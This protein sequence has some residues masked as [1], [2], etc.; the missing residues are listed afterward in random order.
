MFPIINLLIRNVDKIPIAVKIIK[1]ISDYYLKHLD[2]KAKCKIAEALR[3]EEDAE[4]IRDECE[5]TKLKNIK[6]V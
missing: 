6:F 2:K 1:K 4:V 5:K 3:I